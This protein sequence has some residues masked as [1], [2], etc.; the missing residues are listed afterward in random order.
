[1]PATP[2]HEFTNYFHCVPPKVRTWKFKIQ[3]CGVP[4]QGIL[5]VEKG[6]ERERVCGG[7]VGSLHETFKL[8]INHSRD[9]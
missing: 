8:P 2:V 6:G 7:L 9:R 1:M 4:A 3:P 5:M